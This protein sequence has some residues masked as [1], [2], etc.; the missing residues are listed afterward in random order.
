MEFRPIPMCSTWMAGYYMK[1]LL[2]ARIP[3]DFLGI[4]VLYGN[5]SA[6]E[7]PT[8][9]LGACR[10]ERFRYWLSWGYIGVHIGESIGIIEKKM[11]A[12]I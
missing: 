10:E 4:N 6:S 1:L 11:E 7:S 3:Y 5:V 2:I 8:A 12:T 9:G